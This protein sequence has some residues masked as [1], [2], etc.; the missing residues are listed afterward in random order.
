[1]LHHWIS[2]SGISRPLK[3]LSG[4]TEELLTAIPRHG[5]R[6]EIAIQ[7]EDSKEKK[8]SKEE[9]GKEL[10]KEE[11]VVQE[12]EKKVVKKPQEVTRLVPQNNI[13]SLINTLVANA[14]LKNVLSS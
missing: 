3:V 5:V 10:P 4:F 6:K 11:E 7:K 12:V 8:L 9:L 14:N 1:M 2:P 13:N